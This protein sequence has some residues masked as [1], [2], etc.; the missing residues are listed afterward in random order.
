MIATLESCSVAAT[1]IA[2]WLALSLFALVVLFVSFLAGIELLNAG[3]NVVLETWTGWI[4]MF[5]VACGGNYTA[6][7]ELQAIRSRQ[8]VRSKL[9]FIGCSLLG[10]IALLAM[11][12]AIVSRLTNVG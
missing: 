5:C 1:E 3:E 12:S 8:V 10:V 9:L 11:N 6:S 7:S 4:L 2:M